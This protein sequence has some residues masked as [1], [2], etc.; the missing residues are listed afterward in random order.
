M[1]VVT[2]QRQLAIGKRPYPRRDQELAALGEW[3]AVTILAAS[4]SVPVL[5]P[6][7]AAP[8]ASRPSRPRIAGLAGRDD[9]YFVG[10]RAEQRRWPA[11]L[12][13]SPLAGIVVCGTGGTGKTTLAAEVT[14][15][16]LARDPGGC[17]SA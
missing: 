13:G 2:A 8:A 11:D 12:T 14:A 9:W 17:W 7:T 16:V 10:R 6:G 1:L 15:R 3:A 5:D 4:G